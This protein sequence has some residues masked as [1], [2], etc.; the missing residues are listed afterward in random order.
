[1]RG[2]VWWVDFDPATGSEIQKTRPA[3]VISDSKINDTLQRVAVIPF[4]SNITRVYTAETIITLNGKPNKAMANQI[5]VA[6]KSR[7]KNKIGVLS[8]DDLN[9]IENALKRYL[10]L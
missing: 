3:V 1:M 6:D 9:K 2:E 4:T 10:D 5:M 7:L 8:A